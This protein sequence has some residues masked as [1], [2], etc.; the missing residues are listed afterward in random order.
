MRIKTGARAM[1][2]WSS[3]RAS[4]GCNR[5]D[6]KQTIRT[7][8]WPKRRMKANSPAQMG[9]DN[10]LPIVGDLIKAVKVGVKVGLKA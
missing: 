8:R 7:Q 9:R 3:P 2:R 6:W 10:P 5:G 4:T 1:T